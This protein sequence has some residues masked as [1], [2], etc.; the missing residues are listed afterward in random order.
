L[1]TAPASKKCPTVPRVRCPIADRILAVRSRASHPNSRR[2]GTISSM[3]FAARPFMMDTQEREE[4]R[5][6]CVMES[7]AAGLKS[8][9]V[10]VTG[11]GAAVYCANRYWTGFR[12]RLGV[13]GKTA[14]VVSPMFFMFFLSSELAM[15]QCSRR[16]VGFLPQED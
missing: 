2:S 3:S 10:A 13:S 16:H 6:S 7:I 8:A 1:D 12:T 14:L 9:A 11:S 4:H 5:S 15:A